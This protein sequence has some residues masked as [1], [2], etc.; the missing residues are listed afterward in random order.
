VVAEAH[1]G[2]AAHAGHGAAGS[3]LGSAPGWVLVVLVVGAL[4]LP[5]LVGVARVRARGRR[6]SPWRTA[7]WAT[8]AV[9]VGAA[10]APPLA[11][12]AHAGAQGHTAQHLVLGVYAPLALVLGSPVRLLLGAGS[13]AVR[14]RVAAVLQAPLVRVVSFPAVAALLDTGGLYLLHLT[15]LHALSQREPLVHAL[16]LA[17]FLLA[18]ALYAWA[19]AG[20]DPAPRR[21]GTA[22]RVG[23][24]VLAAGAHGY[25]AKL[26]YGR[27]AEL[28]PGA[29]GSTADRE[30]AAVLLS[31][32]GDVGELLLATALFGGWYRLRGRRTRR[33]SRGAGVAAPRPVG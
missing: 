29:V 33:G 14:A 18:G 22:T 5:Y 6:W 31:Y 11:E 8:G 15:P 3:L 28:P 21:P 17:H 4:V 9:L 16:V 30:Q 24:L 27:A 32:G 25:L 1:A 10:L 7:A 19:V 20:P 26:L 2:R 23:V 12:A 13:R